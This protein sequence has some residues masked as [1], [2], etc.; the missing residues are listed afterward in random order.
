MGVVVPRTVEDVVAT[1]AIAREHGVPVLARGGGTSQCGQTVNRALVVD[2]S[3]YLRRVLEVDVAG[4]RAWVEPG[5]VLSHLNWCLEEGRAVLS[6]G[7]EH[8]F[9]VHDRGDGGEQLVRVEVDPVWADG[10]QRAGD[11]RDPGGWDAAS[12]RGGA[13]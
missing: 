9:A 4:R 8:E 1:M 13:G 12:V 11:R 10:G 3:K 7:S 5:L 2:C 6:G